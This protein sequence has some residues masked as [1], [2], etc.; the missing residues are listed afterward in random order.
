VRQGDGQLGLLHS[1]FPPWRREE[2][3]NEWMKRLGK[4][5]NRDSGALLA[6]TQVVEQSVD[7][8][9]DLLVTDLAPTDMLF[10]RLGRIWRHRREDRKAV[11]REMWLV[12]PLSLVFEDGNDFCEAL[13][14]SA[15][16]YSPYVLWRS[17]QVWKNRRTVTIPDELRGLLEATYRD[18][19]TVPMNQDEPAWVQ[20]LREEC[21]I[22]RKKL[23]GIARA[24][25]DTRNPTLKDHEAHTRYSTTPTLS[26]LLVREIETTGNKTR[27]VLSNGEAVTLNALWCDF[28]TARSVHRNIISLR[29]SR[30][31][32]ESTKSPRW[33]QAA[34]HGAIGVLRI[35]EDGRLYQENGE[36]TE[37]AYDD[38]HGVYN[39][40]LP[41]ERKETYDNELDW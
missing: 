31:V 22:H 7:I 36:A 10:Q 20:E 14:P 24:M 30:R 27:V 6:S 32:P 25:T 5:A 12:E 16:V 18:V 1:A 40:D 35:D 17:L 4:K 13:G 9:A 37:L 23:S 38:T 8:D 28:P 26:F 15:F 34:V 2:L 3:E 29:K 19:G 39:F 21:L 41:E 11:R 33:L